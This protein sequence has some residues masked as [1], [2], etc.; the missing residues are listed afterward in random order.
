[1][2][3]LKS[4]VKIN[5]KSGFAKE[6]E[7]PVPQGLLKSARKSGQLNL[8]GRGLTEGKGEGR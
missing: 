1:M 4:G 6:N 5:P 3:R 8:S 7:S 2:S